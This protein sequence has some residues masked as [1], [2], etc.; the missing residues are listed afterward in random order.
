MKS[1][2]LTNQN[3]AKP[4]LRSS[5]SSIEL[6]ILLP[7][8]GYYGILLLYYILL[9]S[10]VI[11]IKEVVGSIVFLSQY[12]S[13]NI[14]SFTLLLA[15]SISYYACIILNSEMFALNIIS[16]NK[17]QVLVPCF[18]APGECSPEESLPWKYSDIIY[19]QVYT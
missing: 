1:F 4:Y 5:I 6:Y 2:V 7:V 19:L 12:I 10:K 11:N 17:F 14:I 9:Y 13:L 15:Y 18:T 8:I 16:K 3:H